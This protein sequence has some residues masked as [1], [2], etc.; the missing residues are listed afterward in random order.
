M[1]L[2]MLIMNGSEA[3]HLIHTHYHD[4][5]VLVLTTYDTTNGYLIQ[6]ELV[7]VVIY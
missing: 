4:I 7:G 1:D 6:F 2:K 3:T 5:K